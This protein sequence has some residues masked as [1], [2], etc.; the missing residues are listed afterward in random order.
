MQHHDGITATSKYHIE[1]LFK[2]R[3][4]EMT[5]QLIGLISEIKNISEKNCKLYEGNCIFDSKDDIVYLTILHEGVQKKERVQLFLPKD[6]AY[7]LADDNTDNIFCNPKNGICTLVFDAHLKSG[8]N[9]F[10]LNKVGKEGAVT[11]VKIENNYKDVDFEITVANGE[12]KY[13]FLDNFV[14]LSL[15]KSANRQTNTRTYT[16]DKYG[17]KM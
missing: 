16:W 15:V 12:I 6:I 4:K 9:Y 8:E 7:D 5:N 13:A 2:N 1:T 11:S 14:T 3:M 10:K 17:N